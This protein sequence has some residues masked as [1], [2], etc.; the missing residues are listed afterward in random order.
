MGSLRIEPAGLQ[1]LATACDS[2]S[3]G[4]AVPGPTAAR[5]SAFQAS[6][7]AVCAIDTESGLAG[8]TLSERMT[9][10][11]THLMSAAAG[12]GHHESA[13]AVALGDMAVTV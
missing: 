1:S 9:A 2:W 5:G 13:A 12:Y 6:A 7:G 8:K 10:F 3:T 4:V 11:S